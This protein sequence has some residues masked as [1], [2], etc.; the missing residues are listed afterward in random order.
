MFRLITVLALSHLRLLN[1]AMVLIPENF[2][3]KG[4]RLGATLQFMLLQAPRGISSGR[5]VFRS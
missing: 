4:G 3:L 2:S 1:R 5:K